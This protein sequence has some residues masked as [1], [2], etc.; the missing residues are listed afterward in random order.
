MKNC[1]INL[2][3]GETCDIIKL[4][5]KVF[6]KHMMDFIKLQKDEATAIMEREQQ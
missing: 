1:V 5:N 4:Y 6:L 3:T 2:Q